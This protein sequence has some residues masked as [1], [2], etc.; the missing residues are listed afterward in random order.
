M[1]TSNFNHTA[2]LAAATTL[3]TTHPVMSGL[4]LHLKTFVKNAMESEE[5]AGQ[6]FHPLPFLVTPVRFSKRNINTPIQDWNGY[7]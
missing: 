2:P 3:P 7:R 5:F 6:N 4:L 1:N